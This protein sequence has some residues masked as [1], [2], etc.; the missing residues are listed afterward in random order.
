MNNAIGRGAA[1]ALCLITFGAPGLLVTG[2]EA[3]ASTPVTPVSTPS[4]S[5]STSYSTLPTKF[6]LTISPTRLVVSPSEVEAPHDILVVNRGQASVPVTVQARNFVGAA[7]GT[8]AFEKDAPYAA[9]TWLAVTPTSFVLA[10]GASQTVTATINVPI[11]PEPGDH[12]VALVFLVP[13]GQTSA[14]IKINRG[15]ATPVYITVPGPTSNTSVPSDLKAPG[16]ATGGPITLTASVRDSGTVH[17]DFREKTRLVVGGANGAAFPDFTVLRG[18]TRVVTTTWSPPL[19]CICHPKISIKNA[20][21][22][23][24]TV[25]VRVIVFPLP[26]FL[27]LL[28]ALLLLAFLIFWLRRRYRSTVLRAATALNRSG[29]SGDV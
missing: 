28:G 29:S 1:A 16:F 24:R 21:G 27:G 25:S 22:T 4:P 23:T 11:R 7:N 14:N 19:L 17:R 13:A 10:P 9:A 18:S 15:V 26:L 2:V 6:S 20:D 12:Q 8:L 3:S 5:N